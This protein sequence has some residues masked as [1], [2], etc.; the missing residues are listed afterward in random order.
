MNPPCQLCGYRS[1]RGR[2]VSPQCPVC[3]QEHANENKAD[4]GVER[5]AEPDAKGLLN[6]VRSAAGTKGSAKWR[7]GKTMTTQ[8]TISLELQS[9]LQRL[10]QQS[11]F[12]RKEHELLSAAGVVATGHGAENRGD[13]FDPNV[14]YIRSRADPTMRVLKV[15]TVSDVLVNV[16]HAVGFLCEHDASRIAS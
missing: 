11:D 15:R 10:P 13:N 3:G 9:L 1:S 8:G 5:T 14:I 2:N 12:R 6:V 16:A 7:M 4:D